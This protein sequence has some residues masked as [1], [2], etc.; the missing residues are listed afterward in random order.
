M[1]AIPAQGDV[2]EFCQVENIKTS[3]NILPIPSQINNNNFLKD[4]IYL[5]M[6]DTEREA[7]TQAE[8]KVGSMQEA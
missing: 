8:G 3:C 1:Q 7:E 4:F 2:K 5:F 6:R